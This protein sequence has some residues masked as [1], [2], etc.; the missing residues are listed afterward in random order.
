MS[1]RWH[2]PLRHDNCPQRERW[3]RRQ[4]CGSGSAWK[5]QVHNSLVRGSVSM[6][7]TRVQFDSTGAKLTLKMLVQSHVC[8]RAGD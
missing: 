4:R 7:S 1:D 5:K 8:D 3:I 2:D 6:L